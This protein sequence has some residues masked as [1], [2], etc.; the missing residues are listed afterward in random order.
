[1]SGALACALRDAALEV[2]GKE[3]IAEALARI[4]DDV[5][6]HYQFATPIGWVPI[7]DMES[8]FS[9]IAREAKK[10][11]SELHTE[12]ARVSLEK[13]FRVMWRV[14]LR[15]TTDEALISR[16]PAIFARSYNRGRLESTFPGKRQ[17]RA[18][19]REWPSAPEWPL[20]ATRIGIETVL[21]LAGRT[22]ARV[23]YT[24][25]DDGAEYT[26]TWK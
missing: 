16:T 23:K 5:R 24:R 10:S 12:V 6:A 8:V 15:F 7:A 9:E 1:M 3:R 4:P 21:T 17:A 19:L 25:T 18:V 11:I 2:V 14:L 22:D 20:R 26:A 13:T